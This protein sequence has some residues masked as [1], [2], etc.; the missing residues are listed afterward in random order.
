MLLLHFAGY[1]LLKTQLWNARGN[2]WIAAVDKIRGNRRRPLRDVARVAIKVELDFL[3]HN[4]LAWRRYRQ[5]VR[6][7]NNGSDITSR[8]YPFP[9]DTDFRP[10]GPHLAAHPES[11]CRCTYA[12][13]FRH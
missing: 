6:V 10:I 11:C 13:C 3:Q 5:A 4:G 1:R 2:M 9:I 12:R 7:R 8:F